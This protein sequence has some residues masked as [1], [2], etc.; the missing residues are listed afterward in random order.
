MV[1]AT[2]LRIGLGVRRSFAPFVRRC[3]DCIVLVLPC[4]RGIW[5][6]AES[7]SDTTRLVGKSVVVVVVEQPRFGSRSAVVAGIVD[8]RS[9][10]LLG[11]RILVVGIAD[12]KTEVL[13]GNQTELHLVAGIAD[14]E[15]ELLLGRIR[16]PILTVVAVADAHL[17]SAAALG[18]FQV[19]GYG[20][21]HCLKAI[22]C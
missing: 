17:Q 19:V 11:S 2:D 7:G 9:E 4:C 14:S 18:I 5:P 8:S 13:L 15:F 1:P 22:S 10:V 6:F 16:T 3:R 21:W 12:L 20:I